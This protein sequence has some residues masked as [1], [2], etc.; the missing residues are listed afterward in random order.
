MYI[1]WIGTLLDHVAPSHTIL[2]MAQR[3]IRTVLDENLCDTRVVK[4]R[5]E[6]NKTIDNLLLNYTTAANAVYNQL[7]FLNRVIYQSR[8]EDLEKGLQVT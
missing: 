8:Q 7:L 6:P 5:L 3:K 1:W 2:P 4:V